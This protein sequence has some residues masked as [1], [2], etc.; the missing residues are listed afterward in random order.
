MVFRQKP[1][2]HPH[3]VRPSFLGSIDVLSYFLMRTS[4]QR[5]SANP[6]PMPSAFFYFVRAINIKNIFNQ[7]F[8]FRV[9]NLPLPRLP[10]RGRSGYLLNAITRSNYSLC[11]NQST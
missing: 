10:L 8:K 6:S 4:S 2:K 1:I 9:C 5:K 11:K 3:K 7:L